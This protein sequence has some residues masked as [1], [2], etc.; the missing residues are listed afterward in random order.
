[1]IGTR[2][3]FHNAFVA[4]VHGIAF[5][6]LDGQLLRANPALSDITG[7]TPDELRHLMMRDLI[8]PDH[9]DEHAEGTLQLLGSDEASFHVMTRFLRRD[10]EPFW[11]ELSLTLVRGPN[12]EPEYFIAQIQDIT[13]RIRSEQ[14]LRH[15]AFHDSLTGL[16]N[17]ALFIDRL[18]HALARTRRE[19]VTVAILFLDLDNFK[20]VNDSLGHRAG[21][22]LLLEMAERLR[23]CVRPG[24]TV[25]RISG[26]EFTVLLENIT[27]VADAIRVAQRISEQSMTLYTVGDRQ[28][29]ISVSIGIALGSAG[30]TS[31]DELIRNADTAM[32]EAKRRG[33]A[34]YE[35]F[36]P[37]M[38]SLARERLEL[39]MSLHRAIERGEFVLYYQPIVEL[40]SGRISEVE[41]LVR[42]DSPERGLVSPDEF[43]PIAEESGAI[44]SIGDWVLKT[45]CRQMR[46][47]QERYPD[48]SPL[49][50]GVNISLRQFMHPSLVDTVREVLESSSIAP[51]TLKLEVNE[52]VIMEDARQSASTLQDL[53]D[54][55]VRI[56]LDDFGT[57]L[58]SLSYLNRFPAHILKIDRS[59]VSEIGRNA[60]AT[61][62]VGATIAIAKSLGIGVVAEGIETSMQLEYL[63]ALECDRGQ[64]FYFAVPLR[65][66]QLDTILRDQ[67]TSRA[68]LPVSR[69]SS[70]GDI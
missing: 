10:R 12:A 13:E 3:P 28:I 29:A 43:I 47:W 14:R 31:A 58:A 11:I 1:L 69:L 26:D 45:A 21:D 18:E 40:S 53:R 67:Q 6:A 25:A 37:H 68:R 42:W 51:R 8:H 57:G 38:N 7:Y 17:R 32:Y 55:G 30:S 63:I 62:L 34:R 65:V 66:E 20:V 49:S 61:S 35:V 15:Q 24:D 22:Q 36:D 2:H 33:K 39:E 5:V 70:S 50:L 46:R 23:L 59:F 9:R 54:I 41:A 4:A 48:E 16:P 52:R 64:G 27:G 19:E 44:V 60:G 56:T